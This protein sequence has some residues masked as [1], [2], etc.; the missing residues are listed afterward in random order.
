MGPTCGILLR[1]PLLQS[2][3][4]FVREMVRRTASFVE[5]DDFWVRSTSYIKQIRKR[6]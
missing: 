5:G 3:L 6:D 1:S 4:D 2:E